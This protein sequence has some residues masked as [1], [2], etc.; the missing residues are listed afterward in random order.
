[1]KPSDTLVLFTKHLVLSIMAKVE[2]LNITKMKMET[3]VHH[4]RVDIMYQTL[5]QKSVAGLFTNVS[6]NT[7]MCFS[8][9]IRM[10]QR[11]IYL[12]TCVLSR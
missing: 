3:C 10:S 8:F 5:R 11:K 9:L 6:L 7:D 2:V 1:M 4:A 12:K